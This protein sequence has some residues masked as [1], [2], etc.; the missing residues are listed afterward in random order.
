MNNY[1][2]DILLP[3]VFNDEF[4]SLIPA[5]RAHVNGLLDERQ[6]SS[7]TLSLDRSKLWATVPA[8]S[9][10]EV[11]DILA[12]MPLMKYMKVSIYELAFY[13]TATMGMLQLSLN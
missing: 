13:E 7:Y 5:Q 12:E 6:I 11:M 8:N 1:M 4:V 3:D 10:E 2:I 9:E